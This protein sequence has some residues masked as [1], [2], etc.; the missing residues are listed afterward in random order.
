MVTLEFGRAQFRKTDSATWVQMKRSREGFSG[1]RR[2][3]EGGL[4]PP[5]ENHPKPVEPAI[6]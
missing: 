4:E 6:L 3:L 5:L 1:R 2:R